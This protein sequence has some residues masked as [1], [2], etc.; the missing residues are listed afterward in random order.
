[1]KIGLF[2]GSFNPIHFGHV[3]IAKNKKISQFIDEVWF[4]ITPQ[5]PFKQGKIATSYF[6]RKK[7]VD[8]AL[9]D[10]PNFS[11]SNIEL[12]LPSPQYTINTMK[13]LQKKHPSHI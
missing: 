8:L 1:M 13:Y 6:H 5:S 4:V 11:A 2:F 7:M 3:Q 10:F 9:I 12:N